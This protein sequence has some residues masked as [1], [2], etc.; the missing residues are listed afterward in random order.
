[1]RSPVEITPVRKI[2]AEIRVPGS[3]SYSQ[4]ALVI[5]ALAKGES[6]LENILISEDTLILMRALGA[7]GV[8]LT[9]AGE[10]AFVAGNGGRISN[11]GK[12]LH[13]GNNGTAM[14]FL[15]GVAALGKGPF[16]LTGDP[17]LCERPVGQLLQALRDA[18]V[19][20]ES[21]RGDGCPPVT[22]NAA[23]IPGGRIVLENP[24]SSQFIS[25]LLICSPFARGGMEIELKGSP[26]SLPYIGMTLEVMEAYGVEIEKPAPGLFRSAKPSCYEGR[27]YRIEG[28]ATGA[29]YFFAAAAA[30]GG[31]V[32]VRG[33]RPDSRQG[34]T[35][36]LKILERIGCRVSGTEDWTEVEGSGMKTG[37]FTF[38]MGGM[39]D[40]VPTLAVVSAF[41]KGRTVITNAAH[42]RHKESD[43]I[44]TVVLELSRIGARAEETGDGMIIEGGRLC[45]ADI[46]THDDHRIAM[47]MAVAGLAVPGIR[48]KDPD[49]VKKSYPGFWEEFGK[50]CGGEKRIES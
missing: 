28:D 2:N 32:R 6:V 10:T 39:P 7:L 47:S 30:A 42:L 43:R 48:I 8:R 49:C 20:A 23:G 22:V 12:P 16:I 13:L 46:E 37:E 29:S 45:G 11:P 5:S 9:S 33:V 17:R 38:D 44:R 35:G 27:H 26:A 31:R 19:E 4:R 41:R 40:L 18:G 34:D 25:S 3:K 1:M 36:F 50:L 24:V 21:E 14:R 15:C